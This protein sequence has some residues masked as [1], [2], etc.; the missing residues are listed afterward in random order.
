[1]RLDDGEEFLRSEIHSFASC[2]YIL[3]IFLFII[4]LIL[5]IPDLLIVPVS[6][7]SP[8]SLET[9]FPLLV[10]FPLLFPSI[11]EFI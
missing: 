5:T 2:N 4:A 8:P 1:M 6:R 7:M 10:S 11:Q 9:N 3:F